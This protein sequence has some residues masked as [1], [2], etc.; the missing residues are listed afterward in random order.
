MTT[1]TTTTTPARPV[2]LTRE[3]IDA[4]PVLPLDG[5]AGVEHRVL[6]RDA[7]SMAGVMAVE[8]G[9]HLGLHT[10]RENEH[11]IWVLDG[12]AT[13]MGTDVAPGAYVHVPSGVEHDIDARDSDGCTVLYFYLRPGR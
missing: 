9:H 8:G 4:L 12:E 5:L 10:H 3:A 7:T 1:T 2:V 13:I 6:W 11:H